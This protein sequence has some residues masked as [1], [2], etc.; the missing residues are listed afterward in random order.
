[1][2]MNPKTQCSQSSNKQQVVTVRL[3]HFD[4]HGLNYGGCEIT[5]PESEVVLRERFRSVAWLHW[6][7]E[8]GFFVVAE[9]GD[10]G[11]IEGGHYVLLMGEGK[12]S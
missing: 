2:S 8:A 4:R 11:Y 7:D 9:V 12:I 10:G 5:S 3:R 6:V 1:M